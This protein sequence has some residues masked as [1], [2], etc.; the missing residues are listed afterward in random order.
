MAQF[1]HT[2]IQLILFN[3]YSMPVIGPGPNSVVKS[4]YLASWPWRTILEGRLKVNRNY[5][6]QH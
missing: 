4:W 5:K 3:A 6:D 2:M 1:I